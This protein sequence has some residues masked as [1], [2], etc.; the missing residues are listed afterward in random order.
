M[1]GPYHGPSICLVNLYVRS[2]YMLGPYDGPSALPTICFSAWILSKFLSLWGPCTAS[3]W[4]TAS[5]SSLSS[6][7]PWRCLDSSS[8]SPPW[9]LNPALRSP[10]GFWHSRKAM[11]NPNANSHH[12]SNPSFGYWHC[13]KPMRKARSESCKPNSNPSS[14]LIPNPNWVLKESHARG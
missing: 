7:S 10:V 1:L 2:I 13:R 12:T 8:P 9:A 3:F 14:T 6:S 5:S 4:C 11:P